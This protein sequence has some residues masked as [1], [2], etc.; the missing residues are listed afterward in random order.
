M[1]GWVGQVWDGHS[2]RFAYLLVKGDTSV[3]T[4]AAKESLS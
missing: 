3:G 1:D 4:L 2:A